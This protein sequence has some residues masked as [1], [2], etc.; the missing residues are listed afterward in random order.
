M[1]LTGRTATRLS[2]IGSN[3][4][5]LVS[6]LQVLDRHIQ[7]LSQQQRIGLLR[8]RTHPVLLLPPHPTRVYCFTAP[9]PDKSMS[10]RSPLIFET[11]GG[12]TI[13][14]CPCSPLSGP[15]RGF[16]KIVNLLLLGYPSPLSPPVPSPIFEMRKNAFSFCGYELYYLYK[17]PN[18]VRLWVA[19]IT[20]TAVLLLV[21]V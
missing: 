13:D 16:W 14:K 5:I 8:L 3:M 6:C 7:T 15:T 2:T 18:V 1:Y 12:I 10:H 11:G 19:I 17:N 9:V 4:L 20:N 21:N